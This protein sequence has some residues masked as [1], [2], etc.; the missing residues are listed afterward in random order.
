MT[1]FNSLLI[2]HIVCGG[3]SLML[4]L[5]GMISRKGDKRHKLIEK[6]FFYAILIAAIMALSISYLHPSYFLFIIGVFTSNMLLTGRRYLK[7]K[8][9]HDVS[10][11]D[12]ILTITML[13]FWCSFY[14]KGWFQYH[15]VKLF[16]NRFYRFWKYQFD[17]WVPGLS[18]LCR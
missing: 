2:I 16:R 5:F 18:K 15:S 11:L 8:T 13:V 4:G 12:W 10:S 14:Q 17:I 7:K 3:T 6:I 1:L 9:I